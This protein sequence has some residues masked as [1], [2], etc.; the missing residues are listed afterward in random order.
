MPN[1]KHNKPEPNIDEQ[2][3]ELVTS[4]S[5]ATEKLA[6]EIEQ[7]A[8]EDQQ[9]ETEALMSSAVQ[10]KDPVQKAEAPETKPE[11][12]PT[13]DDQVEEMLEDASASASETSAK[14]TVDTVD[15][16]LAE[17][18]DEMLEGDFDDADA[19]L[20]S[21][22]PAP[23]KP[24]PIP[25]PE[26]TQT[27]APPPMS[28]PDPIEAIDEED[29]LEG[30]FDDADEVIAKGEPTPP[31]AKPAPKPAPEP[32]AEAPKPAPEPVAA[33]PKAKEPEPELEAEAAQEA[34]AP[35]GRKVTHTKP[36]KPK[37]DRHRRDTGDQGRLRVLAHRAGEAAYR[38]AELINKPLDTKPAKAK[39]IAG[40]LAAVTLFNAMAVW[41][42]LCFMRGPVPGNSAEPAVELVGQTPAVTTSKEID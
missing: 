25:D 36:A 27:A 24:A 3:D 41:F 31:K 26:A 12:E 2:I 6:E 14:S 18:A 42:F 11:P 4:M 33:K 5:E 22:E 8:Q 40:W 17:L 10:A 20:T 19:V 35:E 28:E 37:K 15:E 29:L 32:V 13:L 30:D 21:G 7:A 16:E 23:P 39:D 9:F 1:Q 34:P 38:V